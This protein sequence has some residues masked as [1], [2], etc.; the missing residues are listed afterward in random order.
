MSAAEP[1]P[2]PSPPDEPQFKAFVTRLLRVPKGE[3]DALEAVR[4][5]RPPRVS[6]GTVKKKVTEAVDQ[7]ASARLISG[8]APAGS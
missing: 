4:I 7:T 3:I 8:G 6:G 5:K 1:K 2:P